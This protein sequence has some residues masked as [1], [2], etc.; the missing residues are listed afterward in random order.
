MK[1]IL[2]WAAGVIC[3]LGIAGSAKADPGGFYTDERYEAPDPWGV[4]KE[5]LLGTTETKV[6]HAPWCK[7]ANKGEPGKYEMFSTVQHAK[8]DGYTPCDICRPKSRVGY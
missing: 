8:M 5:T 1:K 4:L 3:C 7:L 2:L 6:Y